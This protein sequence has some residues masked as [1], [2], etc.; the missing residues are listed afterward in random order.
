M[1]W[2]DLSGLMKGGIIG[3]V[4]GFILGVVG[5]IVGYSLSSCPAGMECAVSPIT[6][7][8]TAIMVG[9]VLAILGFLLGNM[10]GHIIE[11]R[12]KGKIWKNT[13]SWVKGEI[14]GFILLVLDV[15]ILYLIIPQFRCYGSV[16]IDDYIGVV[17]GYL[18]FPFN[19]IIL[20]I[21]IGWLVEKIKH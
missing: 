9:V 14:I 15:L 19:L 1:G 2:K 10:I 3:A 16:C 12:K 21:V 20:G 18:I 7:I 17:L 11:T 4:V 8:N 6:K 5:I 13:P